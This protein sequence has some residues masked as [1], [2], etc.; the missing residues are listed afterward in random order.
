[1]HPLAAEKKGYIMLQRAFCAL[2][3]LVFSTVVETY[4]LWL[5]GAF[6]SLAP[7]VS[8]VLLYG[9]YGI[10]RFSPVFISFVVFYQCRY[11]AEGELHDQ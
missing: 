2:C 10:F 6:G 4:I 9:R 1:M 11:D 8:V 3:A 5:W 7:T